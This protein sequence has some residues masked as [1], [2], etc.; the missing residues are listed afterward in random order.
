MLRNL[1]DEVRRRHLWPIPV[2]A[3]LVAVAAPLLFLKS[4]PPDAP[5][6]S[7]PAPA[8]APAG[9]LPARAVLATRNA[10]KL[11]ARDRSRKADP[12]QGPSSGGTTTAAKKASSDKK[13]TGTAPEP[14]PV[15]I[16]NPDGTSPGA[17]TTTPATPTAPIG[18]GAPT[19]VIPPAGPM[20]VNVRFGASMPAPLH[21]VIPRL[22]TFNAGGRVVAIFVKYS[23]TRDKAVFA[24]AP[25][26]LLSGDVDCRR[27]EGVC[28]YVDIPAGKGVRLTAT[29]SLGT[30]VTRRLDV[31]SINPHPDP[32]ATDAVS[33][34][35]VN[36][37]CLLGKLL[38]LSPGD[39][40]LATDACVS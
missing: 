3:L 6:A 26:S 39:A 24:I 25:D 23:P 28:R 11:A 5:L 35:P 7:A 4:A 16:T 17:T 31:E 15:V 13:S 9:Q 37:A 29:T 33:P 1:L 8:A 10:R 30:L 18:D 19:K 12:F 36:G 40:S 21:P 38:T 2:V 22:Q 34:A 32:S 20:L 27:K 14:V